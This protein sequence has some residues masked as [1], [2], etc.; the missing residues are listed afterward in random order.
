M[1]SRALSI[2]AIVVMLGLALTGG[3][4]PSR[5]MGQLE[6]AS[7][8]RSGP[9]PLEIEP[10]TAMAE[11]R[12]A[13][14]S[15]PTCDR[16]SLSL[17]L[18]DRPGKTESVIVAR[19][20]QAPKV[21]TPLGEAA[22]NE[23]PPPRERVLS[24][25]LGPLRAVA[26][27][28]QLRVIHTQHES[29]VYVRSYEKP[30]NPA[31][32]RSLMPPVALVSLAILASADELPGDPPGNARGMAL[33]PWATGVRFTSA[34]LDPKAERPEL[35]LRGTC[36]QGEVT[37]TADGATGR[38]TRMTTTFKT[39]LVLEMTF[40]PQPAGDPATWVLDTTKRR[41]VD[42]LADLTI[43]EVPLRVGN[44]LSFLDQKQVFGDGQDGAQ[45]AIVMLVSDPNPAQRAASTAEPIVGAGVSA[46]AGVLDQDDPAPIRARAFIV[47]RRRPE[48]EDENAMRAA[49]PVRWAPIV[50]SPVLNP[51]AATKPIGQEPVPAA[52]TPVATSMSVTLIGPARSTIQRLSPEAEVVVCVVDR[53]MKIHAII[54]V[55]GRI[56]DVGAMTR[57]LREAR[58]RAVAP[59]GE[60][61]PSPRQE[62][63]PAAPER[64]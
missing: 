47:A 19:L 20:W 16:I 42:T 64:K 32:L 12:A 61:A 8:S 26:R 18:P 31:S 36:D 54:E 22:P 38:L 11:I 56:D 3:E 59:T 9:A 39:Q 5:A 44:T 29:T 37:L 41:P 24:L 45:S 57:E 15:A 52:T 46:I 17:K 43:A 1:N 58:R 10:S 30:L 63:A 51:P 28:G 2:V 53:A 49:L 50:K 4:G 27:D 34:T 48:G 33:A 25:E 60:P 14:A 21:P 55:D 13:Y 7:A 35:L 6:R 62:P 23:P 40:E